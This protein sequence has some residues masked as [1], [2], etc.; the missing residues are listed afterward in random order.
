MLLLFCY[1]ESRVKVRNI[2]IK[3][4]K[5]NELIYSVFKNINIVYFQI[6]MPCQGR[7][8]MLEGS[9]LAVFLVSQ[10]ILCAVNGAF[11]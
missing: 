4:G 1:S 3:P 5:K 2:Y 6:K 8:Q 10:W 11:K 7:G 9:G